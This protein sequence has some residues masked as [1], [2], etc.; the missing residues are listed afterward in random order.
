[1]DIEKEFNIIEN[2]VKKLSLDVS[3]EKKKLAELKTKNKT[4]K[5]AKAIVSSSVY[6]VQQ[7]FQVNIEKTVNSVLRYIWDDKNYEFKIEAK[8]KKDAFEWQPKLF[9]DGYELSLKPNNPEVGSPINIIGVVF[10]IIF[11]LMKGSR[12]ILFFDEPSPGLGKL[13]YRFGEMLKFLNE[14]FKTQ[15]IIST[16]DEELAN[17]ADLKYRVKMKNKISHIEKIN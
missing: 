16:H 14:K 10:K 7:K 13:S 5:K 11:H 9:N 12:N 15:I 2:E 4:Y 6:E 1:M 8:E 3:K 17:M